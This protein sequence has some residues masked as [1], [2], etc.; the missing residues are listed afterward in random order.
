MSAAVAGEA[1]AMGR[2]EAEARRLQRQAVL[3]DP[4][5]RRLFEVAG[6]RAG[7]NVLDLGSGVGD[8]AML[9]AELVGPTGG[10]GG[11]D[12]NP[13]VLEIA[14]RRAQAAGHTN[15]TFLTGA[16]GEVPLDDD[17]DAIVGRLILCHLHEPAQTVRA[18]SPHLRSGGVVAFHDL[19]LTTDGASSPPSPLHQQVLGWIKAA[20]VCGGVEIAAGTK[21]HQ[22]FLDAGLEAP[23]LQVYPLMGGSRPASPRGAPHGGTLE[24]WP[25]REPE[26][27]RREG[28]YVVRELVQQGP[29]EPVGVGATPQA[30]ADSLQGKSARCGRRW[31]AGRP[32]A[33][34]AAHARPPA[35]PLGESPHLPLL[36]RA[37]GGSA[38]GS[39]DTAGQGRCLACCHGAAGPA[40]PSTQD[41]RE[42]YS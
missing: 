41:R 11:V 28:G 30:S 25:R 37:G 42:P 2:T 40:A 35:G 24:R 12:M 10:G 39:E 22:I 33:A 27:V 1:S 34:R 31:R 3:F 6:I 32:R 26:T 18:V 23:E 38:F 21:M 29:R 7:M 17:F 9:A 36:R 15:V 14:R 20:L 8:T 13:A 19:D 4:D 16:I 5:T